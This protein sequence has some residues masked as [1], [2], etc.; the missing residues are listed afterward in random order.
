MP[1][2]K[3]E[4]LG[5]KIEINY[6]K[7]EYEK[8]LNLITKFKER[9]NEFPNDGKTKNYSIII[10]AALKVEDKLQEMQNLFNKTKINNNT[11]VEQKLNNEKL[12]KEIIQLKD[13]L[14]NIKTLNLSNSHQNNKYI[15]EIDSLKSS[16]NLIQ[17]KI[18]N[19]IK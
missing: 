8:L 9:L 7:K 18:K 15:K 12:K 6:E 13:E 2:L 4:I 14:N 11:I 3:T 19:V 17:Q 10:L 5:L 16:L 1:I